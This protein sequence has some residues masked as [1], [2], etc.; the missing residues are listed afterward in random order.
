[1]TPKELL[2]LHALHASTIGG[3]TL[4]ER[5]TAHKKLKK[6]LA[7]HDRRMSDVAELVAEAQKLIDAADIEKR[8]AREAARRAENA[9]RPAGLAKHLDALTATHFM[10]ERYLD[11]KPHEAIGIALWILHTHVLPQIHHTPRLAMTSPIPGCGKTAVLKLGALL[12]HAGRRLGHPTAAALNSMIEENPDDLTL[13]LDEADTMGLRGTGDAAKLRAFLND[14]WERG[15]GT[16]RQIRGGSH[17]FLSFVPVAIAAIGGAVLPPALLSRALV[18]RMKKSDKTLPRVPFLYEP[19]GDFDWVHIKIK[20]WAA[21]AAFNVDDVALPSGA[22]INRAADNWRTLLAIADTFGPEWGERARGAAHEFARREVFG[23][24]PNVDLLTDMR[25]I[26]ERDRLQHIK[27][28]TLVHALL[29]LDECWGYPP[30]IT[31]ARIAALL[32]TFEI[33]SVS[34]RVK[35]DPKTGKGYRRGDLE[36][37]WRRY[38]PPAPTG[39]TTAQVIRLADANAD[40]FK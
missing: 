4:P 19:H 30:R 40:L 24:N 26:F 18:I 2:R 36:D 10:V 9:T 8:T 35:G 32:A 14:G 21:D 1:M 12:A 6:F 39:G 17:T 15:G 34:V 37:A 27:S 22:A 31:K 7:A 23:V 11:V 28:D 29:D 20:A 25:T 5:E 38:C 33:K 3:A 13:L 16:A